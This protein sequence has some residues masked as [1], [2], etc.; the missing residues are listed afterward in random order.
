[1]IEKERE[2]E[3]TSASQQTFHAKKT[4]DALNYHVLYENNSLSRSHRAVAPIPLLVELAACI[5]ELLVVAD[6]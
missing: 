6:S 2:K 1:L 3:P 5:A 4:S